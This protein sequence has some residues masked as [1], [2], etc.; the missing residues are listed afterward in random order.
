MQPGVYRH[1]SN[2]DYHHGPGDSKSGLDLI[3]KSPAHLQAVRTATVER[4]ST[5]S[6]ALG[7][8]FHMLV[9]EP[10]RFAAE[11]V[12]HIDRAA[13]PDA[14]DDRD[15]LVAMVAEVNSER[16]PKL[17][18][19]GDKATLV[20]RIL[21]AY[22][23][24]PEDARY[25]AGQL[26]E[27]KGAALK[28]EIE[29][30]NASRAGLYSLNGTRHELAAILRENG[31]DVT[32]W[33]DIVADWQAANE[34]RNILST[35]TWEQLHRMR[36]AVMAHPRASK[37]VRAPGEAEL[38]AYWLEPVIDPDTGEHVIDPRTGEP[39]YLLLRCR[40]D[41][42]R[43]DGILVDLKSCSPG[44]AARLEFARSIDDWRYWVQHPM[45]L[46]GAHAALAIEAAKIEE[47]EFAEF[48]PPRAFVFVAVENDACVVDGV[49]KGVAVYELQP[50]SV[51]L[52][53]Q[54]RRRDVFELF[55]CYVTGKWP[56]YP[57][58]VQPIDL[59]PYAFARI[60]AQLGQLTQE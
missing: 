48:S 51:A 53:R 42:W 26:E 47:N 39:A 18:T 4:K 46:D 22:A 56:G 50:D 49:A 9:L 19:S 32:L 17:A 1:L 13:Y 10:D 28:A 40:P 16:L 23:D 2:D 43:H 7:T 11:Y 37:L 12:Q 15:Q 41:Y 24:T 33:S 8:A 52:G 38:S 45:Y 6:Q 57:D 31:R 60:S 44:G 21:A 36:D 5:P 3:A 54:Q 25:T 35:D 14:I 30:L 29:R 34:G 20:A 55:R 58:S 59:P 27:M